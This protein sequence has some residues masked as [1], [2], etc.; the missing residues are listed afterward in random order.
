[1]SQYSGFISTREFKAVRKNCDISFI[2]DKEDPRPEKV[3]RRVALGKGV[4][5]VI[6][7]I[8]K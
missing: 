1:M 8:I 3:F 2:S 4:K 5:R 6:K 7:R